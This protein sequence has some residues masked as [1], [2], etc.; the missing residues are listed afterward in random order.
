MSR[1]NDVGRN[2]C[3]WVLAHVAQRGTETTNRYGR[4]S[5]KCTADNPA[6]FSSSAVSA[7]SAGLAAISTRWMMHAGDPDICMDMRFGRCHQP[8]RPVLT[9]MHTGLW[10]KM[11]HQTFTCKKM[12]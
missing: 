6:K 3:V 12:G 9:N 11:Q 7:A 5:G 1:E 8:R 2:W 10:G 4:T